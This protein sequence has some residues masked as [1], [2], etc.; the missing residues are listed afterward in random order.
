[1][2]PHAC[3][4]IAASASAATAVASAASAVASAG[5]AA[6]AAAASSSNLRLLLL[7]E[8][9]VVAVWVPAAAPLLLRRSTRASSAAS[10][11]TSRP[12]TCS[13]HTRTCCIGRNENASGNN[14]STNLYS[15][16]D[17]HV[18]CYGWPSAVRTDD[19]ASPCSTRWYRDR[20]RNSTPTAISP[21]VPM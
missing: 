19:T 18:S 4:F 1:M 7:L 16:A 2:K 15:T 13:V 20:D 11:V 9:A 5:S 10:P 12:A 3:V 8:S 14:C 21:W 6:A 17:K